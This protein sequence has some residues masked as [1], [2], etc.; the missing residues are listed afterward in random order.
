M[1]IRIIK[2]DERLS[3]T[4]EGATFYYRRMPATRRGRIVDH[5]SNKRTGMVAWG[6]ATIAMLDDSLLDWSGVIEPDGTPI[7]F[8]KELIP[9][10]PDS[11]QTEIMERLNENA[12]VKESE[13][14]NFAASPPSNG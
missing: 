14:K 9:Y 5:H 6:K 12:D 11:V 13:L 3:V 10:L 2:D 7:P 1:A 8:S 4:I